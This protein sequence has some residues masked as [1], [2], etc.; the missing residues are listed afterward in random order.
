[1][2]LKDRLNYPYYIGDAILTLHRS[3]LAF[4]NSEAQI[5]NAT[6][7]LRDL[8]PATWEDDDYKK[9][10]KDAMIIEKKD[11]RPIVAGQIR[12]SEE[13]CKEL[14]LP[15]YEEIETYNYEKLKRACINLIDR[16]G[17]TSKRIYTEK[18]TGRRFLGAGEDVTDTSTEEI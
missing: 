1:M 15:I 13:V 18:F 9:D 6:K 16:R 10:L 2:T 8:L 14:G 17:L 3:I 4:E 12:I 11:V 7:N 5:V